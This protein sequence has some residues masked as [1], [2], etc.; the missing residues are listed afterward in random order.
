MTQI[1]INLR[2]QVFEQRLVEGL[3]LSAAEKFRVERRS[4]EQTLQISICLLQSSGSDQPQRWAF[5]PTARGF[6]GHYGHVY[7]K[8]CVP[9]QKET[10]N[11]Q[12]RATA[13]PYPNKY[14]REGCWAQALGC[15][16]G[17]IKNMMFAAPH[18][19]NAVHAFIAAS[20]LFGG[21]CEMGKG[22]IGLVLAVKFWGSHFSSCQWHDWPE[23][24]GVAQTQTPK[25]TTKCRQTLHCEETK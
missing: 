9:C 3:C 20:S 19:R 5:R 23:R 24:Q 15:L 13:T 14:P 11:G 8:V 7:A 6:C 18:M 1:D 10:I 12:C 21:L 2:C 17:P 25:Y 22:K 16:M 4:R